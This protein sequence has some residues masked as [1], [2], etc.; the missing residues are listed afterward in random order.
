MARPKKSRRIC[1]QPQSAEFNVS[2]GGKTIS[3]SVDEYEAVRLIDYIGLT[4]NDCA[5]QMDV[6][7]TTI[8]AIYD[9][10]KYKL[11]DSLIN[12]KTVKAEGGD[13]M[14]CPNSKY[15]CGKCGQNRC[16]KCHH[17]DCDLCSGIFHERG[18]ECFVL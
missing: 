4:Q 9:S 3:L 2:P 18:R 5:K 6:A 14:L 11:A 1:M 17:G 7:R 12:H 10:A 13:Y 15:C 8:T 16:G